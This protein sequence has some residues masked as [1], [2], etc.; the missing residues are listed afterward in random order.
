MSAALTL[1]Q[2]LTA[3]A[4][5]RPRPSIGIVDFAESSGSRCIQ[6]DES[7]SP[8]APAR[9]TLRPPPFVPWATDRDR[10]R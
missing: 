10:C 9:S 4:C 5:V 1:S 8:S 6:L 7:D 3:V 2:T